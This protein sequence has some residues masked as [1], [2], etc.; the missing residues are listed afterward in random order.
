MPYAINLIDWAAKKDDFGLVLLLRSVIDRDSRIETN[1]RRIDELA[2]RLSCDEERAEAI[3]EIIRLKYE[4][5]QLRCYHSK[6]GRSW[7]R[8]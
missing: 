7:K 4:R 3:V 1:P 8:V 5:H 6:T 2:L